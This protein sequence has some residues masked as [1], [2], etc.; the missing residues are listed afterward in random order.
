L[1]SRLKSLLFTHSN[2][3]AHQAEDPRV[4]S[5]FSADALRWSRCCL[6]CLGHLLPWC[7]KRGI[8][9]CCWLLRH[10]T[11]PVLLHPTQVSKED[12]VNSP[13]LLHPT[14]VSH[15]VCKDAQ[16]LAA[17]EQTNF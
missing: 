13:V 5:Q 10:T 11:S 1:H 7:R 9:T 6:H 12:E 2:L 4:R 17:I 16:F 8:G 3:G 15:E 14:Q